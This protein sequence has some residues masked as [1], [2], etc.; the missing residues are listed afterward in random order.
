MF[1]CDEPG[2][3]GQIDSSVKWM[4]RG[5]RWRRS[6]GWGG[7]GKTG[8]CVPGG[9]VG[10]DRTGRGKKKRTG[11]FCLLTQ[12]YCRFTAGWGGMRKEGYWPKVIWFIH[13]GEW[14]AISFL[15]G[16]SATP[17]AA[18]SSCWKEIMGHV[19]KV[20]SELNQAAI[21][22][23]QKDF[24]HSENLSTKPRESFY[25]VLFFDLPFDCSSHF[26]SWAA[27]LRPVG[28]V[29]LNITDWSNTSL[30]TATSS[31]QH[32][33]RFIQMVKKK[34]KENNTIHQWHCTGCH[35]DKMS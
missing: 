22:K 11:N 28:P 15:T 13:L 34:L 32:S 33:S 10:S 35:Q 20:S 16:S 19:W 21:A 3:P 24:S 8:N 17:K 25:T 23:S 5:K 29:G 2:Q 14:M 9:R 18:Q 27:H 1:P 26:G 4:R 12:R 31:V 30:K 6:R 7:T